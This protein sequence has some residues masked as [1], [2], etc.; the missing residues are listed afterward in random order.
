MMHP[1]YLTPDEIENITAGVVR[2]SAQVRRLREMGFTVLERPDG[3]PLVGRS[4][5][6]KV[7]GGAIAA[8]SRSDTEAEARQWQVRPRKVIPLRSKLS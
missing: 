1:I 5:F 8:E 3:T 7:T 6:Q 4:H 2:P